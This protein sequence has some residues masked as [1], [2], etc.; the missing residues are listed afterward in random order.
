MVD[1]RRPQ[2]PRRLASP[3]TDIEQVRQ[4]PGMWFGSPDTEGL[5][6]L[7][8]CAIGHSIAG[9]LAGTVTRLQIRLAQD[10]SMTVSDDGPGLA[11]LPAAEDTRGL[12]ATLTRFSPQ[13]TDDLFMK[14]YTADWARTKEGYP[15][16]GDWIPGELPAVNAVSRRLIVEVRCAGWCWRQEYE[17]G[18]PQGPVTRVGSVSDTGTSLTLWPDP[19]IFTDARLNGNVVRDTLQ[20]CAYLHPGLAIHITDELLPAESCRTCFYFPDGLRSFVS[21][22]NA[23]RLP[24]HDPILLQTADGAM[25]LDVALQYAVG[26]HTMLY[27]YVNNQ[28][29]QVGGTHVV[30]FYKALQHVLTELGHQEHLLDASYILTHGQVRCGL[31][32][33]LRIWMMHPR[34]ESSTGLAYNHEELGVAVYNAVS[35]GLVRY[36]TD[37]PYS[38]RWILEQCQAARC[39]SQ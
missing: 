31:A 16:M 27:S 24:H 38:L 17:R 37:I 35:A 12:H 13:R 14:Q 4:R 36:F 28:H 8:W 23:Q 5:Y 39:R 30:G 1:E 34:M 9:Y 32:A 10:G 22:L 18:L 3:L 29:T 6:H 11:T 33:V 20:V 19:T 7:L 15:I 25:T 26:Q 21:H 2:E